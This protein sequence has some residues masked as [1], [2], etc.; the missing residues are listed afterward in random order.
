[1]II[2][3]TDVE[4]PVVQYVVP[5]MFEYLSTLPINEVRHFCKNGALTVRFTEKSCDSYVQKP[6]QIDLEK[7]EIRLS[8]AYCQYIWMLCY[9]LLY[10]EEQGVVKSALEISYLTEKELSN[11]LN[12]EQLTSE[13]RDVVE[14]LYHILYKVVDIENIFSLAENLRMYGLDKEEFAQ[15]RQ[16][17]IGDVFAVRVNAM[18]TRALA[19]V[20]LHEYSHYELNHIKTGKSKQ[21]ELG[22]DKNA[23]LKPFLSLVGKEKRTSEYGVICAL[24]SLFFLSHSWGAGDTH[25]DAIER[26]ESA[27]EIMNL[28][29][30]EKIQNLII[31]Y[32]SRWSKKME[33]TDFPSRGTDAITTYK[34]VIKY[35]KK[36]RT[37][38]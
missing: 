35:L 16:I 1:M 14:Y 33:I 10:E 27:L 38:K 13:Q 24:C 12:S 7:G 31:Q 34:E 4:F 5:R 30:D 11:L 22:A 18:V 21:N 37:S 19:F 20:L 23:L 3:F 8:A 26:L 6:A 36:Y 2:D 28:T 9:V 25:P 15:L 29:T 32:A 17:E